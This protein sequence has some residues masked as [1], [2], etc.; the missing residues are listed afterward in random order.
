MLFGLECELVKFSIVVNLWLCLATW[1]ARVLSHGNNL[2]T[3]RGKC[4][5]AISR[6]RIAWSLMLTYDHSFPVSFNSTSFVI[7]VWFSL[8]SE[9]RMI[10]RVHIISICFVLSYLEGSKLRNC[11]LPPHACVILPT[12][13]LFLVFL[14]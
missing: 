8:G 5:L 10:Y 11:L 9:W 12:C 2:Y 7:P 14:L 1:S 3:N 4:M 13:Y 6:S